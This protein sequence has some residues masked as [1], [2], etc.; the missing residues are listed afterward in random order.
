MEAAL[1]E[2]QSPLPPERHPGGHDSILFRHVLEHP[3]W[4]GFTGYSG[5]EIGRGNQVINIREKDFDL[6]V[7]RVEVGDHRNSG[8]SRRTSRDLA[9]LDVATVQV[10]RAGA[11]DGAGRQVG[12]FDSEL[13]VAVP[14]DRPLA[15]GLV[16]D[17]VSEL[18][19]GPARYPGIS[20]LKTLLPETRELET[21]GSVVTD[22]SDV[23][24]LQPQ[25]LAGD[26]RRCYL[27]A[28]VPAH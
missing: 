24:A 14:E 7:N 11:H 6:L 8:L 22:F 4:V 18:A 2:Q 5:Q 23:P 3:K 13:R 15:C 12:G 1:P 21:P 28:R 10:K 27:A 17:D 25:A 16:H 26:Q 20:K 9:G 19:L